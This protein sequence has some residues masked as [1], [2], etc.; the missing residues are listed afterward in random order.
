MSDGVAVVDE[1]RSA[2]VD[3]RGLPPEKNQKEREGERGLIRHL[4]IGAA[5]GVCLYRCSD[6]F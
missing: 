3:Q 5:V 4:R 6:F 2:G 1:I